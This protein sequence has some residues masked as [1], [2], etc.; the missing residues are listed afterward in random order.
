M[1][2]L[3]GR[4]KTERNCLIVFLTFILFFWLELDP[5][6]SVALVPVFETVSLAYFVEF[7]ILPV[8]ILVYMRRYTTDYIPKPIFIVERRKQER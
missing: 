4:R 7:S 3:D 8:V 6:H 1:A 5:Y 2:P